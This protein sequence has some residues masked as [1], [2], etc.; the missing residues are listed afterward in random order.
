MLSRDT[1][2][3][4]AEVY[5][6]VHVQ[7][8]DSRQTPF[9]KEEARILSVLFNFKLD[10]NDPAHMRRIP[11]AGEVEDLLKFTDKFIRLIDNGRGVSKVEYDSFYK[12]SQGIPQ[13][14]R[15]DQKLAVEQTPSGP[16]MS[17]G[18][19]NCHKN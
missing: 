19:D 8:S 2:K 7:P 9:T 11:A 17:K 16:D 18:I 14:Y 13:V 3:V 6:M 5:E 15:A 10:K 4:L 1:Y 12:L